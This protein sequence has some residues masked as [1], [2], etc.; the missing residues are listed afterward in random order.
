M[1]RRQQKSQNAIIEAFCDLLKEKNYHKITV[2]EIIDRADVG[3]STFYSHFETKDVLLI[4]ICE[5]LFE[6]IFTTTAHN[7]MEQADQAQT[8]TAVIDHILYH[9]K[10]DNKDI[11]GILISQGNGIFLTAFKTQFYQII[12]A[13]FLENKN[14]Y[15][16]EIPLDIRKNHIYCSFLGIVQMWIQSGY[17]LPIETMRAYYMALL[18]TPACESFA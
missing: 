7:H 10:Y 14:I 12:D 13:Y 5:D 11:V 15:P 16:E 4:K 3:R 6:H 17:E 18:S 2:Q 8:K 9:I 1:D